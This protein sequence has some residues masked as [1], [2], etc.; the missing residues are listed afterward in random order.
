[1]AF[2]ESSEVLLSSGFP[3]WTE[4]YSKRS[5]AFFLADFTSMAAYSLR[6]P[7]SSKDLVDGWVRERV[8]LEKRWQQDALWEEGRLAEAALCSGN[9]EFRCKSL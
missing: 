7:S 1:M 8:N 9:E 2:T 4:S 6:L 3:C 5:H